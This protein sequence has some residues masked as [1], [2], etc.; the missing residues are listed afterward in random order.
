ESR[1]RENLTERFGRILDES[2][3]EIFVFDAPSRRLLQANRG[4]REGLGHDAESIRALTID[5]LLSGIADERLD[6][7]VAEL[8]TQ[9]SPR[10]HV[11]A[12]LRRRDGSLRA[13]ELTLQAATDAD[14]DV[15]ILVAED[16]RARQQVRAL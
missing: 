15:I 1:R 16:A 4:A 7:L 14:A 9:G 13:T 2:A 8:R 10:V 5:T 3:N 6:A 12:W 11:S